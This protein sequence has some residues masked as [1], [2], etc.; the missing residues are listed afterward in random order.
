MPLVEIARFVD[1]TE[2]QVAAAALRASGIET[3][4]Q[5]ELHAQNVYFLQQALGYG[6]LVDEADAADAR[7]LIADCRGQPQEPP[8]N[9]RRGRSALAI[10]VGLLFGG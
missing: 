7:A 2:A 6:L 9:P 8:E 5:G 3:L 4:I 10:A 1:G